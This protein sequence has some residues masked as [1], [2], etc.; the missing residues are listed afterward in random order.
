MF[1]TFLLFLIA[2][3]IFLTVEITLS[4]LLLLFLIAATVLRLHKWQ[5]Q[6][7]RND[8]LMISPLPGQVRRLVVVDLAANCLSLL[9]HPQ[10]FIKYLL[11]LTGTAASVAG[12]HFFS[13][14]TLFI[15]FFNGMVV[16][17]IRRGFQQEGEER[18]R[19]RLGI[20]Q[21]NSIYYTSASPPK[22]EAV[23]VGRE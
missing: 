1:Y 2:N 16:L 3:A 6:E 8:K 23:R 13:P 17:Q 20:R 22:K 19:S 18:L 12:A 15:A 11:F 14:L 9:L 4:R 7:Q 21:T 5:Q 10:P